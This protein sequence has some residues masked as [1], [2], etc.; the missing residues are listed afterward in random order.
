ME[1]QLIPE[2]DLLSKPTGRMVCVSCN[3]W[4]CWHPQGEPCDITGCQCTYGHPEEMV[5]SPHG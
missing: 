3:R 4:N 5:D 1:G 2:Y